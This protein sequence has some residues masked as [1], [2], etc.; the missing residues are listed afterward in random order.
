MRRNADDRDAGRHR[1]HHHRVRAD[2]GAV[3]NVD[4]PQHFGPGPDDDAVTQCRVAFALIP[5]STAQRNAVVKRAIVAD[6]GRL[7]DHDPHA[8]VDKK[9][10]PI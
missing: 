6:H 5:T 4:R 1:L 10:R 2:P 7:A 9:R 8:V 3:A